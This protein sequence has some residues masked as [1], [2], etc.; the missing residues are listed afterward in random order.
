MGAVATRIPPHKGKDEP[1]RLGDDVREQL[2]AEM[3]LT[4]RRLDLAG[5]STAV[6]EGGDGPPI[7]LLHGPGE[8]A[9][10]WI[11]VVPD[12][13]SARRVIA[14]DL[15][16]HGISEV[17]EGSLAADR[18]LEW[19]DELIERTCSAP[20]VL[21]GQILGGAIAARFA[22][23]HGDR[24]SRL[25]LVDTLG[26]APFH[27]APEFGLA[28]TE[29]ITDPTEDTHDRLWLRC[30][31]DLDRM[32]DRMGDS[33]NWIKAYNL[34]RARTPSL[35]AT[36]QSL[37]KQFGM[38]AIP[39][40]ELA[41]IAVPTTLIWGRHDLATRLPV[42]EAANARYGWPLHVIENAADDPPMEQPEAFVK[43]LSAALASS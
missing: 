27:P 24:L 12:L 7:V 28:L 32:R 34:D 26:L 15:P 25:V 6:L 29:F 36:Q 10:K 2:M 30:A 13:V 22:S 19:L 23:D 39:A 42:A 3:P 21:V 35:H 41:R 20:P 18:V 38:P 33:W 43:A 17:P 4:E 14:P 40:A 9:A 16:G 37:M 31:F 8:Y 5:I 11:R 1:R